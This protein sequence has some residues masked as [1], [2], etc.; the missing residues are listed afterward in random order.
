MNGAFNR[1]RVPDWLTYADMHGIKVEGRGTWRSILC[2][3]HDDTHASLRIN[4]KS[5]G[6][7][8]MSCA[9]SGGDTLSHLMQRSGLSFA[10]AA[11]DLGAW[12]GN[13]TPTG[14]EKPRSLP[15]RDALQLVKEDLHI[16][17]LVIS[18]TVKGIP[19]NHID[20][21]A[22]AR[23]CRNVLMVYEEVNG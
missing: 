10:E 3:F 18:D 21:A 9:T 6:W 12:E 7:R 19:P 20:L 22:L 13:S 11:K 4:T 15:A 17:Y 23:S 5:G 14:R 16:A 2:D 8:C 1:D